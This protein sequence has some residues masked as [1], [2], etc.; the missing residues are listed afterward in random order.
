MNIYEN[1]VIL[2]PSLSEE[3]LKAALDKIGDL[4]KNNGGE[5]LK[6]DNWGK[7]KLSYELNK[8]KM[9]HY[10]MFIMKTPPLAIK[11]IENYFKVY[12]PVI[13]FMV[14]KLGKKQ[15]AALPKDVFAV[16]GAQEPQASEATA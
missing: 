5:V 4:V 14:I 13:K 11:K 6:I 16:A 15:I 2:N 12:D 10:I 1:V 3:E 9:G 8:Q 7:R